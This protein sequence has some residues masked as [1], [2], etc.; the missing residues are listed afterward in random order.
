[1][2]SFPQSKKTIRVV[3]VPGHAR[4]RDQFQN[5]MT[6][7]KAV[8]FVVDANSISRNGAAV[9]ELVDFTSFSSDH[10]VDDSILV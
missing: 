1:V 8:A 4:L 10:F 9:A 3:D 6:N 7:A 5:H 2:Y